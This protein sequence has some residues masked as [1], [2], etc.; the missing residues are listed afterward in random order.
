MDNFL[1]LALANFSAGRIGVSNID[2]IHSVMPLASDRSRAFLQDFCQR[3]DSPNGLA[4]FGV[5][6]S[7]VGGMS[8][9]VPA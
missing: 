1:H 4:S 5:K 3:D 9:F 8:R 6:E 2:V 7:I